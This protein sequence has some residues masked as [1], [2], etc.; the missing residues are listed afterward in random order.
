MPKQKC[1]FLLEAKVFGSLGHSE[2]FVYLDVLQLSMFLGVV[3][4][5]LLEVNVSA[6]W[7]A[8]LVH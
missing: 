4:N 7:H 3:E 5:Q 8:S 2:S 6:G 1:V